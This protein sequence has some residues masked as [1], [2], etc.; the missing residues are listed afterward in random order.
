MWEVLVHVR[1]W[2]NETPGNNWRRCGALS[3]TVKWLGP[4]I[5]RHFAASEQGAGPNDAMN[6]FRY[7]VPEFGPS[8]SSTFC[9]FKR[10]WTNTGLELNTKRVFVNGPI[11]TL[12]WLWILLFFPWHLPVCLSL[13]CG[14]FSQTFPTISSYFSVSEI[15]ALVFFSHQGGYISITWWQMQC[16]GI[17]CERLTSSE[18][19]LSNFRSPGET[20]NP[21][22]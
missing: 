8:K 4:P 16:G 7:S 9:V 10:K 13:V 14:V 21:G 12:D 2:G 18:Y 5:E 19:K 1:S 3:S 20:Y 11:P 6:T 22:M 15:N 17:V